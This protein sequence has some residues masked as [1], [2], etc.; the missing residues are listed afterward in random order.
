MRQHFSSW[1][2]HGLNEWSVFQ[3]KDEKKHCWIERQ[4]EDCSRCGG[5]ENTLHTS[6]CVSSSHRRSHQRR[7]QALRAFLPSLSDSEPVSDRQVIVLLHMM[8][9]PLPNKHWFI[10]VPDRP[11]YI[12]DESMKIIAA[13]KAIENQFL[14]QAMEKQ[15]VSD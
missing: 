8:D 2:V 3:E 1:Q 6:G 14:V 10:P 12:R 11:I 7:N 15:P 4:T 9:N 13:C 5:T